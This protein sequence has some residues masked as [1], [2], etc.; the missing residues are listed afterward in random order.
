MS[1]A[2]LRLSS[3]GR[4]AAVEPA[5]AYRATQAVGPTIIYDPGQVPPVLKAVWL[6]GDQLRS[7]LPEAARRREK[8]NDQTQRIY[9]RPPQTPG[10]GLLQSADIPEAMKVRLRAERAGL[11]PFA[12]KK[13]SGPN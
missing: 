4:P 3:Q 6:A 12:L 11:A 2:P 7:K 8:K 5:A 9:E 13:A 1:F 10:Q